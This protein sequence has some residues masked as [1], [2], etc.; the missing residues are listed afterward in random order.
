MT[1]KKCRTFSVAAPRC[2]DSIGGS[3]YYHSGK[4]GQVAP[5][6]SIVSPGPTRMP[7]HAVLVYVKE[8]PGEEIAYG[9]SVER[10]ASVPSWAS[11]A[12]LPRH[13]GDLVAETWG[14]KQ[15]LW[16]VAVQPEPA[17]STRPPGGPAR[18]VT[19]QRTR[20]LARIRP[21]LA[22]RLLASQQTA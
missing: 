14:D 13:H 11:H 9:K 22:R 18:V 21:P 10:L 3:A 19:G 2:S 8:L 7:D 17:S 5:S 1:D 20:P 12:V 16:H 15:E 4:P 6:R